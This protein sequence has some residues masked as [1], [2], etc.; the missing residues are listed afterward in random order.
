[1]LCAA[2]A[3]ADP[4]TIYD[5]LPVEAGPL[6]GAPELV[7]RATKNAAYCGG[8]AVSVVAMK[9]ASALEPEFVAAMTID[10][11][12][13]LDFTTD[14][15]RSLKRFDAFIRD[16]TAKMKAA[17]TWYERRKSIASY[18]RI[19]QTTRRFAEAMTRVE[20]PNDVR[21]GELAADKTAAFCEQ[22]ATVATPLVDKA[23]QAA[24]ACRQFAAS[25]S[26]GWWTQACADRSGQRDA[27]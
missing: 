21:T 6:P 27:R 18:A 5:R 2:T 12:H 13:G 10:S 3:R 1:M 16:A 11:P 4:P 19:V 22:L 24:A 23:D 7:V 20:I 15:E 8:F 17:Q 26:D 9:K 14:R 25:E